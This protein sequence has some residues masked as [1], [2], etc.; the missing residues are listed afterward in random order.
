MQ[1]K[2]LVVE[3]DPVTQ[4]LVRSLLEK[5]GYLVGLAENGQEGIQIAL[6]Y[7]PDLI[8]MDVMMPVMDGYS[9]VTEI[10]K[11]ATLNHIPV[12][13]L[14]ALTNVEQKIKGFE[15]G[16]DDYLEK[17]FDSLEFLARVES[18]LRRSARSTMPEEKVDV[19][20]KIIAVF[21]LRGGSGVS[22]LAANLVPALSKL[23]DLETLL[24]DLNLTAGQSALFMNMPLKHSFATIGDVP[25]EEIDLS[26]LED[27][28]LYNDL[29]KFKV[30]AAPPKPE[31]R[32][33]FNGEK[34]S[35]ILGLLRQKYP[36]LVLDL[37]HD[38]SDITLTSIDMADEILLLVPP[39]IAGIRSGMMALRTLHDLDFPQNNIKVIS[40]WIFQDFGVS[41]DKIESALRRKVDLEIPF[42]GQPMLRA[43]NHGSPVVLED[44]ESPLG[45]LFEDLAF[46]LSKPDHN[47]GSPEIPNRLVEACCQ[48]DSKAKG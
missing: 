14:T 11:N 48:A 37:P 5:K 30:L 28:L 21:S 42:A 27:L 13:M 40:N 9:A 15:V 31:D 39:E 26:L 29:G 16:A 41:K 32:D 22:T 38:F 17:P 23:W 44:P 46:A 33:K 3:D 20:G 2:I 1:Q 24:V 19:D 18:L 35:Y 8:V 47:Q 45:A 12:I 10:R 7:Q 43:L 4:K 34:I 6:S 36:Y 25:V